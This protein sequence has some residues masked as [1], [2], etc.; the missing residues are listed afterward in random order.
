MSLE[1]DW[2]RVELILVSFIERR[3]LVCPKQFRGSSCISTEAGHCGDTMQ[4]VMGDDSWNYIRFYANIR[5]QLYMNPVGD[6]QYE[7]IVLNDHPAL[8]TSNLDFPAPSSWHSND[9]FIPH[10]TIPDVWKY[11]TRTDDRMTLLSCEKVLPLPIEGRMREDEPVREA[12]V[13]GIVSL[14]QARSFSM[15]KKGD[16]LC[17]K[18]CIDAIWP[19]V[20]DA[21]SRAEAFSQLPK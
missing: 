8:S 20:V 1:I 15:P 16:H 2:S 6:N 14:S 17:L 4:R 19:S 11:M 3:L 9:V 18:A 12:V 13:F 21:N 10:P 5:E 7:L